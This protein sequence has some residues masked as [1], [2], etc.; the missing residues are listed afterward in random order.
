MGIA[1]T[2]ALRKKDGAVIPIK[3]RGRP[4]HSQKGSLY[5]DPPRIEAAIVLTSGPAFTP[6]QGAGQT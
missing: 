1:G 5:L 4:K 3:G 2:I 6:F